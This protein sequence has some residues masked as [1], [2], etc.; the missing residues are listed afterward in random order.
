MFLFIFFLS[1]NDL[2]DALYQMQVPLVNSSLCNST[3]WYN[4]EITQNM[5]CAGY[6]EGN[7][8]YCQVR[9]LV[10]GLVDRRLHKYIS[11]TVFMAFLAL[12]VFFKHMER[13]SVYV[14][15]MLT[16]V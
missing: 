4:G 9:K 14:L 2:S 15:C 5:I 10:N 8:G 3:E 11:V 7:R 13:I 12:I 1:G 6:P 16:L